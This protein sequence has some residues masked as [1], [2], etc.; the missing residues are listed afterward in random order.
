MIVYRIG[1][2][3]YAK[4]L[5]GEGARLHGGRWNQIGTS[6][7]YTSESRALAVLE[8]TVNTNVADIP[9][10]LSISSIEIP[11][12]FLDHPIASLPGDWK[13]APAPSSTKE[14]GSR[15]LKAMSHAVLRF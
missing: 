5:T 1:K 15:A 7:I 13:Q 6:C 3:R 8:Y 2:T 11:D 10:S 4:D 9:R 14:F 12:A